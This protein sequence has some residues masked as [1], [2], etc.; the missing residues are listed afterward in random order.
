MTINNRVMEGM[1]MVITGIA[2]TA[3]SM[4]SIVNF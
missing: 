1:A 3:V 2:L 4:I